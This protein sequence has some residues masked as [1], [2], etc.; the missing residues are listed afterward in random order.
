MQDKAFIFFI[1]ATTF[2]FRSFKIVI[3]LIIKFNL[4][5]KYFDIIN[6]FIKTSRDLRSAPIIYYLLNGFKQAS[7]VIKVDRALYSLRDFPVL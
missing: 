6:A 5:I 7:I 4:E 2:A 3:A 1:Y